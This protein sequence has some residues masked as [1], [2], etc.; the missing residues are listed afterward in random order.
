MAI[1]GFMEPSE[2]ISACVGVGLQDCGG[3]WSWFAL[4]GFALSTSGVL[5]A[6]IYIWSVIFRNSP[7]EAYVRSELFELLVSALLL[8]FIFGAA[9]ALDRLTLGGFLPIDLLPEGL[10]PGTSVYDA[11]AKYFERVGDDMSGWLELNYLFNMYIDQ[12]A[13]VTPYARPLGVGLVAS[14]LAGMA[15][16]IKQ[17]LYNMS[18]AL[19]IA[20][21]INYAQLFVYIFSLQAFL[22]YYLPAGIFLRCFT[23][24]R[25]L[26][27]TLI[28]IAVAFLFIYPAL[29]TITYSMMYNRS[30]GPLLTFTTLLG[31]YVTDFASGSFSDFFSHNFS[32]G[33]VVDIVTGAFGGLGSLLERVVGTTFL[34]LLIFPISIVSLAFAV[35]FVIPAF[36]IVVFIQAAKGLSKSFGEEVDISALTRL[37]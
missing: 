2:I 19:S 12:I 20:F 22:K 11:P 34:S 35:G 33:G 23:P 13:S 6:F 32:G 27:G 5:L 4:S 31:D 10:D 1:F 16:P 8:V 36:N 24:T 9:G 15:S 14:P 17:L 7:L 3:L 18:V 26:G 29:T 37:I 25:R 30:T 28:G 21:V